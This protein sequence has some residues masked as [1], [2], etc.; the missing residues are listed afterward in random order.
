MGK[1][2]LDLIL[3]SLMFIILFPVFLLLFV[4]LSF[5]HGGKPFFKQDRPGKNGQIFKIF[6]FKTMS[7]KRDE[8]GNL[9]SDAERIT[10]LGRLIRK[11]SL[12]E[13]PQLI[14]I[15]RGEMSLVGPRPL[16]VEYLPLYNSKQ[17][18]RHNVLPGITGW[19]QINGRN[20]ISWE[21][22]FELDV[23]YVN[24]L[25]LWLDLKILFI[26]FFNVIRG[27]GVSQQGH[28]SMGKFQGTDNQGK[29]EQS[30]KKSLIEK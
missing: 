17:L 18:K 10:F 3:A 4:I 13:I 16:L 27:K 24:N 25:S 29:I 19:A 20:T 22:K 9:L 30:H 23:W 11:S 14:N 6:K 2:V 28:V 26:T 8:I 5:E 1:R 15:L 7:D 21:E 12:D